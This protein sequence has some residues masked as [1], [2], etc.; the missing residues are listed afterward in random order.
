M[1]DLLLANIDGNLNWV[2]PMDIQFDFNG[3]SIFVDD[4][5]MLDQMLV[6]ALMTDFGT[7]AYAPLYGGSFSSMI[8]VKLDQATSAIMM[9]TE[10][11]RI[12]NRIAKI[13]QQDPN[14]TPDQQITGLSDILIQNSNN[15]P[16]QV[17]VIP[18]IRTQS[19]NST[20]LQVPIQVRQ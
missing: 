14:F 6:K 5:Q 11:E 1:K 16:R 15:D 17:I 19:G 8:G 3:D 7:D 2:S 9:V 20:S 10:V 4:V 13:T 12:V 18:E